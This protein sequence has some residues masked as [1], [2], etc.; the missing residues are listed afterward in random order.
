MNFTASQLDKPNLNFEAEKILG[1]PDRTI[2]LEFETSQY[3]FIT[4]DNMNQV[5]TM[6]DK[7]HIQLDLLVDWLDGVG[8]TDSIKVNRD[9]W[10]VNID[11]PDIFT[12]EVLHQ[13]KDRE[14]AEFGGSRRPKYI[15]IK[16]IDISYFESLR[17]KHEDLADVLHEVDRLLTRKK[18]R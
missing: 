6:T 4:K 18:P 16:P 15:S 13:Q 2:K 17:I 7:Y 12:N 14:L 11:K 8:E 10:I 3:F 9:G 5:R 1:K